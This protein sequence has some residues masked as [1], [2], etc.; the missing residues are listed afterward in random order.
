MSDMADRRHPGLNFGH[1]DPG[2]HEEAEEVLFGFWVF[3][4]SDLVLFALI[5]ATYGTML[6]RLAGGPG[7]R[8]L[9]DL[10][11]AAAETGALLASSFTFGLA[12]LAVKYD[13]RP[14]RVLTWLAIT[15]I[16]G[17]IFLGFELH[18]FTD[19]IGHGGMPSRSG[20]LSAVFVLLG[21]HG[22]HVTFG[23]IWIVVMMI[24]L[25]VFGIDRAVKLRLLRLGLF[26]HFLDIVWIGIFSL[27][28]L[29]GLA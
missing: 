22:L 25:R 2:A 3:L 14:G 27:V 9:F 24:Q 21:T 23:M 11:S 7:A 13:A 8:A 1:T 6:S 4:M 16:L 17:A 20:F 10:K 12:S 18:D 5:F 19:M 29:Q 28:Y 15:F 26:W